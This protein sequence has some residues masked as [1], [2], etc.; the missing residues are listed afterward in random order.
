MSEGAQDGVWNSQ[1]LYDATEDSHCK[2]HKEKDI[3]GQESNI[4]ETQVFNAKSVVYIRTDW[5]F[6]KGIFL[7]GREL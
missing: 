3:P 5:Y 6:F 7:L 4:R 1:T 2:S